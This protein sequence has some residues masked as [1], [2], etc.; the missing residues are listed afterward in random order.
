MLG[1]LTVVNIALIQASQ[2]YAMSTFF[3][4]YLRGMDGRYQLEKLAGSLGEWGEELLQPSASFIDDP[5]TAS[6]LK[7]YIKTFGPQEMM[8]MTSVASTEV[9]SAM[10]RQ[11]T[12]LF[13]DLMALKQ[14]LL[15]ALPFVNSAE[16]ANIKLQEA[17]QNGTQ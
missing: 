9:Q 2:V 4:Y 8:Q 17:I 15:E 1:S 3:G 12:A 6:S 13:G 16:E 14:Q 10:E 7:D 5:R 11:V